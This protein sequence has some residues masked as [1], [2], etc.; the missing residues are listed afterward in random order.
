MP[1]ALP[2]RLCGHFRRGWRRVSLSRVRGRATRST[3][4]TSTRRMHVSADSRDRI[5]PS[6]MYCAA[7]AKNGKARAREGHRRESP[8]WTRSRV[9]TAGCP[10]TA[11]H[12]ATHLES[13]NACDRDVPAHQQ[14]RTSASSQGAVVLPSVRWHL[15]PVPRSASA[16]P[17]RAHPICGD[18]C[19]LAWGHGCQWSETRPPSLHLAS[20]VLGPQGLAQATP[21]SRTGGAESALAVHAVRARI[22]TQQLSCQVFLQR[23]FCG[24]EWRASIAEAATLGVTSRASVTSLRAPRTKCNP[25]GH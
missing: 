9:A 20:G 12:R 1:A 7:T 4:R 21:S 18:P 25:S 6:D 3:R 23:Q 2:P 24:W 8:R 17:A 15:P 22:P 16:Q 10:C 5:K 11:T 19:A 13:F 14:V